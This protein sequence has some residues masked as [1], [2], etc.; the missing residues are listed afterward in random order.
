MAHR[1]KLNQL[2]LKYQQAKLA[3]KQEKLT[4]QAAKQRVEDTL[5]AQTLVQQ[6]A[7]TVQTRAHSQIAK[8]VSKCLTA[9]F[10]DEAYSFKINFSRKRG[11][12]EAELVYSRDGLEVDPVSAAGGGVVDVTAFALRLACLILATPKR[13]R[14]L[15]LDEPFKH[16]SPEYR[17]KVREMLKRLSKEMKVQF[18]IVTH[19]P[20]LVCGKEIEI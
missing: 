13:R 8:V 2:L 14:L 11:K 9:V 12:T 4:L 17:S 6:V 15:V 7:E 16:L 20:E 1:E 10:G 18:I 3:V 19:S 5:Y